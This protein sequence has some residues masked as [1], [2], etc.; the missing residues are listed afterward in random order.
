MAGAIYRTISGS[1]LVAPAALGRLLR[2]TW[3]NLALLRRVGVSVGRGSVAYIVVS[4]IAH[5]MKAYF[6]LCSHLE[7]ALRNRAG[8]EGS[9]DHIAWEHTCW[10]QE[11]GSPGGAFHHRM[12]PAAG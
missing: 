2:A 10:E 9:H 3:R 7:G 12:A 11:P 4:R 8:E 5:C 1:Q 6:Q